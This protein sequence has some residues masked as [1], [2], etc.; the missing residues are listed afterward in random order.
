MKYYP[1]L[2]TRENQPTTKKKTAKY[3]NG[4]NNNKMSI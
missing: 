3:N 1:K 2:R 4:N